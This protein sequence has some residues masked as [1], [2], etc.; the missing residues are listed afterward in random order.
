MYLHPGWCELC[1]SPVNAAQALAA[2]KFLQTP[3]GVN[4]IAKLQRNKT[5][6]RAQLEKLFPEGYVLGDEA[7]AVVCVLI[8]MPTG[9]YM[10][11]AA[12]QRGVAIQI[13]F[14]PSVPL[15]KTRARISLSAAHSDA[16]VDKA[17]AVIRDVLKVNHFSRVLRYLKCDRRSRD[18]SILVRA[19]KSG[20]EESEDI[21]S[22]LAAK[23][24]VVDREKESMISI[25]ELSSSKGSSPESILAPKAKA[26]ISSSSASFPKAALAFAWCRF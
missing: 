18:S 25:S 17:V 11:R 8:D 20:K 16:D 6:M 10:A 26:S 15:F 21:S 4:R 5:R 1:Q 14:P 3:E 24:E 9:Y 22:S 2:L 23:S 7:S 13:A 12:W 19:A